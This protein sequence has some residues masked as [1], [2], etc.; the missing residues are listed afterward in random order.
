MVLNIWS[1]L[2]ETEYVIALIQNYFDKDLN[3]FVEQLY[4]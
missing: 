4:E 1:K 3:I 2:R